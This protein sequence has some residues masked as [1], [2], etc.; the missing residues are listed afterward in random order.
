MKLISV[1]AHAAIAGAAVWH[2][3]FCVPAVQATAD[4]SRN[5]ADGLS[6]ADLTIALTGIIPVALL[7]NRESISEL[8]CAP[9]RSEKPN[10]GRVP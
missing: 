1:P 3:T 4:L 9:I 6:Q 8:T 10:H 5:Q 7:E 2:S